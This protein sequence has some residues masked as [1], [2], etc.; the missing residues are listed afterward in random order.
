MRTFT[1]IKDLDIKILLELS[2]ADLVSKCQ[3]NKYL[4]SLCKDNNLWRQKINRDF[5]LRGKFI[6]YSPYRKLYEDNPRKLYKIISEKSKIVNLDAKDFPEVAEKIIDEDQ[7]GDMSKE[8]LE[9]ITDQIIPQLAE[10]PLLRGDVIRFKWIGTYENDGKL[11]WDGEQAISLDY[12]IDQYGS[13]PK[14]FSFPEFPINH[15][16]KSIIHNTIIWIAPE[17]VEQIVR[18]F[19]VNTQKSFVTDLY[20]TYPVIAG[21]VDENDSLRILSRKEFETYVRKFPFFDEDYPSAS[22]TSVE[23]GTFVVGRYI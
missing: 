11:M 14:S 9:W 20:V 5:P 8:E 12:S 4:N 6:W 15:F 2:Y 23:R 22:S 16:K 3:I 21:D 1:K 18:N 19:D 7:F 10:L 17:A 13:I